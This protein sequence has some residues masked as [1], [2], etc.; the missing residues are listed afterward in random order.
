M[1]NK[2]CKLKRSL[3]RLK[4]SPKAWSE[5]FEKAVTNYEFSQNRADHTM[6]YKHTKNDKVRF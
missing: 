2:V 4:Q 3:D 1:I 5:C 6:F